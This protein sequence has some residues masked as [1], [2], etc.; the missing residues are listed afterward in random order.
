MTNRKPLAGPAQWS[1][2]LA[3]CRGRAVEAAGRGAGGRA[4]AWVVIPAAGS[5][6]RMGAGQPK[7]Y[8]DLG[9][10]CMLARSVSAFDGLAG[11]P[12]LVIAGVLVVLDPLDSHWETLNVAQQLGQRPIPCQALLAGGASRQASVQAGLACIR[13]AFG[14]R[15]NNGQ[16]SGGA[17]QDWVLVHDAA[18][19]GLGLPSLQRLVEA[20]LATPKNDSLAGGLLAMPVAD[21]LKRAQAESEPPKA[22]STVAR[23]DL[24]GA[25][26]PQMFRLGPLACALEQSQ[27]VTDEASAMEQVGAKPLL[28]MGDDQNKKITFSG[29]LH[30]WM[31]QEDRPMGQIRVGQGFDVHA[32]GP[33][34]RLMVG[35]VEIPYHLGLVG[36]SDA[37]VLLHA[38]SDAILGAMGLGDIGQHFP[39]TDAAYSGADSRVLLRHVVGLAKAGG[40]GI[41]Q[42]DATI[43]AQ[44]PKMAPHI[45]QMVSNLQADT[46]APLVN[47]KAT[48]TER[49]GFTGRGEG[50]AAQAV[51]VLSPLGA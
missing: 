50:I 46:L 14:E 42:I 45:P 38:I 18:R 26:T 40:F 39:D 30:R 10:R 31:N 48:T 17:D 35:G 41:D 19:P 51:V 36:H 4:L 13:A 22:V 33:D 20:C 3:D 21:T 23:A 15:S 28:V 37:D 1:A 8:L 43:V 24:W 12:T 27:D 44:A 25:Q 29:D 34:R 16:A 2:W 6:Q 9:G 7:Q 49:L 32:L 47:V 5:G 11:H